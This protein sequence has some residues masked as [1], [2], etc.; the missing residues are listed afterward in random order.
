MKKS[1][2][3]QGIILVIVLWLLFLISFLAIQ[4]S[5]SVRQQAKLSINL[6]GKLL[7]YYIAQSAIAYAQ[8]MLVVGQDLTEPIEGIDLWQP[9]GELHPVK[10]V[11]QSDVNLK[12]GVEPETGKLD[13]N[14]ATFDE[15]FNLLLALNIP[16]HT[17]NI[18]ADS[19][20]DWRDGDK[21]IRPQGAEDRYYQEAGCNY[22]PP[23][24]PFKCLEELLLVRGINYELFWERPGL[25][26][27][28]TIHNPQGKIDSESA[29]KTIK[30]ALG[31]EEEEEEGET[32]LKLQNNVIYRFITKGIVKN[33]YIFYISWQRFQNNKWQKVE[34]RFY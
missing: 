1:T 23:N 10:L 25:W 28:F 8:R 22:T 34:E 5:K 18:I 13:L 14:N 4:Y 19:I 9:D 2:S 17:A 29:S 7:G 11:G 33:V 31:I 3:R 32:L 27:Y 12:V 30:E 26:R 16:E 21:L 20:I 24:K 15:I 6:K